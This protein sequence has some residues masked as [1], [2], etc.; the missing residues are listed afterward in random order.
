[1][2]KKTHLLRPGFESRP[3]DPES[4]VLNVRLL[5]LKNDHLFHTPGIRFTARTKGD[6]IADRSD[7]PTEDV[8]EGKAQDRQ[9]LARTPNLDHP[10]TTGDMGNTGNMDTDVIADT[11]VEETAALRTRSKWV[12]LFSS[13]M[14]RALYFIL[15]IVLCSLL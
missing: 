14:S 10:V 5:F 11:V 4:S 8:K 12:S 7:V 1:M 3:S 6:V 15:N 9:V 2:P 13:R